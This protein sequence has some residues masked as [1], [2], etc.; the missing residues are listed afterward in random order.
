MSHA[1]TATTISMMFGIVASVIPRVWYQ[2]FTTFITS[3][4]F[5]FPRSDTSLF[6]LQ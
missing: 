3:T 2:R 6:V 5:T 4:G 1:L